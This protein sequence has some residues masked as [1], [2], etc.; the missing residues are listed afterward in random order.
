MAPTKKNISIIP[1]TIQYDQRTTPK[2]KTLRV[3][4]YCR[5]STLQE[6]QESSYEA[7]VSYYTEKI[8]ANANWTLAGIY[9]DDGKSATNI[10]KRSDFQA[11]IDDCMAGKIDMVIWTIV[12]KVDK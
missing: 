6:Q 1:A 8:T 7:Q 3:A 5:V 11:M 12:N 10:R 2:A 9:A 4:A